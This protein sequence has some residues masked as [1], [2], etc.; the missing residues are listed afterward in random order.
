MVELMFFGT[1]LVKI[2]EQQS[3]N[4]SLLIYL[5]KIHNLLIYFTEVLSSK[6][7]RSKKHLNMQIKN[8][9]CIN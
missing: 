2:L 9:R 3:P 1:H 5:V 6:F 4:F 8:V 7:K